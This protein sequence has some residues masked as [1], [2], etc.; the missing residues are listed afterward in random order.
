MPEN[1]TIAATDCSAAVYAGGDGVKS[2]KEKEGTDYS[3]WREKLKSRAACCAADFRYTY[4]V[5]NF[6]ETFAFDIVFSFST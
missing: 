2:A 6:C 4:N 3:N 1:T 5:L